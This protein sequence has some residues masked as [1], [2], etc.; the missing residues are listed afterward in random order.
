MPKKAL[1]DDDL[2]RAYLYFREKWGDVPW[3]I[4]ILPKWYRERLG[5]PT[6]YEAYVQAVEKE[7]TE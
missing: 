3:Y 4:R 1:S 5:N 6:T 7:E 2:H